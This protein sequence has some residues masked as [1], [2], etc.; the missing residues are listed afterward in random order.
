MPHI[1]TPGNRRGFCCIQGT[2]MD[3]SHEGI[4]PGGLNESLN[5]IVFSLAAT[6]VLSSLNGK[7]FQNRFLYV[8]F[9]RQN[10]S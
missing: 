9:G 4:G 8:W 1:H 7:T 3:R 6:V 10:F 2:G 5:T